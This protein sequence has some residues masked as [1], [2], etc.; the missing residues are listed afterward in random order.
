MNIRNSISILVLLLIAGVAMTGTVA[1]R[2]EYNYEPWMWSPETNPSCCTVGDTVTVTVTVYDWNGRSDI[3]S[4]TADL[5]KYGVGTIDLMVIEECG[6]YSARYSGSAVVT[7][8]NVPEEC[9]EDWYCR[10]KFT[11]TAVDEGGKYG[12]ATG[13]LDVKP[14]PD[15]C[16]GS[17]CD[18]TVC[19]EGDRYNMICVD[20]TCVRNDMIEADCPSCYVPH[21]PCGGK[22]CDGLVCVGY[23]LY[24]MCC[25]NGECVPFQW[26]EK[27]STQCGYVAPEPTPT[28]DEPEVPDDPDRLHGDVTGDGTVTIEDALLLF[29]WVTHP[30]ERGTT[31]IL[32]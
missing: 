11:V 7:I 10:E 20:G 14:H 18:G 31:Y 4:V 22:L 8:S 9:R 27:N 16:Y 15:P 1:A 13:R 25:V 3:E 24:S 26:Y 2:E 19:F 32:K 30:D 6:K 12:S 17:S 23:D 5:S 28:P 29:D 21:D